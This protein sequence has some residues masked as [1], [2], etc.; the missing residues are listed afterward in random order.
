MAVPLAPTRCPSRAQTRC[1]SWAQPR[2][3]S[4][5]L[6]PRPQGTQAHLTIRRY[7]PRTI[8]SSRGSH[9][10]AHIMS[11]KRCVPMLACWRPQVHALPFLPVAPATHVRGLRRSGGACSWSRHVPS[12]AV[13]DCQYKP[14]IQVQDAANCGLHAMNACL[15][16]A[17]LDQCVM[18]HLLRTYHPDSDVFPTGWFNADDIQKCLH[19][20]DATLSLAFGAS[21][22]GKV[23]KCLGLTPSRRSRMRMSLCTL[24]C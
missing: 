5:A 21:H 16:A 3:P 11:K 15:Q 22:Y 23:Q 6:F 7:P 17:V 1:P 14:F 10:R 19:T 4:R 24:H 2:L 18:H 12:I 20:L 8:R 13:A 9:K